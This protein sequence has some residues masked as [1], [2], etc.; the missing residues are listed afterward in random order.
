MHAHDVLRY[1][2]LTLLRSLQGLPEPMGDRPGACGIW[3]VKDIIAHLGSYEIVLVDVLQ[4][5]DMGVETPNLARFLELGPGYNDAEVDAR[6]AMGMP[7]VL[8]ELNEAHER[9][10][11]T[12]AR[13]SPESLR[14]VGTIPWYGDA[15]SLDDLIVYQYYGHKREHAAQIEMV[16]DHPDRFPE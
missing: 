7:E 14:Q 13:R 5:A 4:S 2:H 9:S 6:R 11:A 10:L 15:Y 8:A 3:S 12:V 1:G 16:R